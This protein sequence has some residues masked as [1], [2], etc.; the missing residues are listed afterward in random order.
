MNNK[1]NKVFPSFSPF[2]HK[3]SP[4]NRLIDVFPNHFSFHSSNRSNNQDI[5]SYLKCLD[6]ITIQASLDLHSAAVYPMP[7][8]KIK[9]LLPYPTLIA[10]TNLASKLYIM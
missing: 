9:S 6:N 2:N 5:K 3:F 8:S 1:F 4:G 10:T 7:A